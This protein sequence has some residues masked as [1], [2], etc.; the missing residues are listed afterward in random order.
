MKNTIIVIIV[1]LSSTLMGCGLAREDYFTRGYDVGKQVEVTVGSVMMSWEEGVK[2]SVYG[3]ILSSMKHELSYSGID[4]GV[5]QVSY[6]EYGND[7]ARQA[8]YQDLKYDLSTSNEIT[9]R[10][11]KIKVE[12]ADQAKIVF[13]VLQEPASMRF[14]DVPESKSGTKTG[15]YNR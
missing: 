6:R 3:T 4:K 13:T 14:R 5:I 12:H 8:F 9:F 7:Y 2:N 15:K 1:L 10:D 11:I